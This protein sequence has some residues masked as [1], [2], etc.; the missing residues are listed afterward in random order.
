MHCHFVTIVGAVPN[1]EGL[2]RSRCLH[3]GYVNEHHFPLET[4]RA[5]DP[6]AEPEVRTCTR[7]DSMKSELKLPSLPQ[8]IKNYAQAWIKH[9][10]EGRPVVSSEVILARFRQ[11]S[12]C[13]YYND[14]QGACSIC[15][16]YVNLMERGKAP[17]ALE[18]ADKQCPDNPPRWLEEK[19][20]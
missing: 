18:W 17:N 15:G 16:C 8:R 13:P 9:I 7:P 5:T 20:G 4:L 14:T 3:C 1:S 19:M 2:V 10:Q 6:K 11:C 12:A